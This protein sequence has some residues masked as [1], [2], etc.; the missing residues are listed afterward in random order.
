MPTTPPLYHCLSCGRPET[1]VPLVTLRY[2]GETHFICSQCFP[3]LIHHPERLS[4]KLP[5]AANLAPAP[6]DAH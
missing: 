1:E 2:S 5:Q 4:G 6:P 3:V